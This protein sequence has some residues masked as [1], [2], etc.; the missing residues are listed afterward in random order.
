MPDDQG[1]R[2]SVRDAV[3]QLR[4][5]FD[6]ELA[7]IDAEIDRAEQGPSMTFGATVRR[8]SQ[9]LNCLLREKQTLVRTQQYVVGLVEHI[10]ADP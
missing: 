8:R 10:H 6:G 5:F 9:E 2:V 4:G 1:M 3:I 7:R